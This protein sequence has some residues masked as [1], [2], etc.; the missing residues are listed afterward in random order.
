M[1]YISYAMFC[2]VC[3]C[4]N[5]RKG[6]NLTYLVIYNKIKKE[7]TLCNKGEKGVKHEKIY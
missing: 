7:E 6:Y 2:R 5:T 4:Y 3:L 1:C